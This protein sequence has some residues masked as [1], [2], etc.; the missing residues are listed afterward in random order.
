MEE[1]Q[2]AAESWVELV[3]QAGL[4]GR[5]GPS[6]LRCKHLASVERETALPGG[7]RVMLPAL[8][9]HMASRAGSWGCGEPRQMSSWGGRQLWAVFT[10]S[11]SLVHFW[12]GEC[13]QASG[14]THNTLQPSGCFI[15]KSP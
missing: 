11:W 6:G 15:S 13:M 2:G 3:P 9:G 14:C 5:L 4:P 7:G 8:G 12:E 1:T 10:P